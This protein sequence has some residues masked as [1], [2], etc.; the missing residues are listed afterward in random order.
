MTGAERRG[1]CWIEEQRLAGGGRQAGPALAQPDAAAAVVVVV[2][3]AV[4][5]FSP[6]AEILMEVVWRNEVGSKR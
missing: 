1:Q 3:V 6:A 5:V 2:V 4:V